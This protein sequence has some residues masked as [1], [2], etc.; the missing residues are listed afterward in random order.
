MKVQDP[1]YQILRRKSMTPLQKI[2]SA[3]RLA[4]KSEDKITKES[5]AP[6]CLKLLENRHYPVFEF[7]NLHFKFNGF[8]DFEDARKE[9]YKQTVLEFILIAKSFK[10]L[11]VTEKLETTKNGSLQTAVYLSGTVRAFA[12]ACSG[13]MNVPAKCSANLIWLTL[14]NYYQEYADKEGLPIGIPEV[15][16]SEITWYDKISFSVLEPHD[17]FRSLNENEQKKHFMVPVKFICSRAVS[18]ELVR[19]RPCSFIQASQRYCNYS[20]EKFGREVTFITPSAFFP[21][22]S[23]EYK[24]WEE[25]MQ[26][27]ESVYMDMLDKGCTPQ[28]AR[29]VLPNSCATEIIV[30]ATLKEWEHIMSLRTSPRADPAMKQLMLPLNTRLFFSLDCFE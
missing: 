1:D 24:I 4:Y 27:A 13:I 16:I 15:R 10:Y 12:E 9:E 28:A 22:N 2:E 6:F 8:L 23:P 29:N 7:C 30:Y 11:S 20:H 25:S 18:H 5:A 26:R 17:L 14:C 3:A 21:S 19:H